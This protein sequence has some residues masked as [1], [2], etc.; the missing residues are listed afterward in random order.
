MST[1]SALLDHLLLGKE[2][3]KCCLVGRFF[4]IRRTIEA[5][6]SMNWY[7]KKEGKEQ[8]QLC[9]VFTHYYYS[10]YTHDEKA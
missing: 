2:V 3:A 9:P 8:M 7:R 5:E 10:L 1:F 4:L 6:S